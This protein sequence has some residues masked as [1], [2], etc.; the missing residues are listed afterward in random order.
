MVIRVLI[1]N[2]GGLETG[3][4]TLGVGVRVWG[5]DCLIDDS[6]LLGLGTRTTV[7]SELRRGRVSE[8]RSVLRT[9]SI[10]SCRLAARY[11]ARRR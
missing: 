11:T 8:G 10:S 7:I 6:A 4:G 3:F 1:R 5:Y 9:F 2:T